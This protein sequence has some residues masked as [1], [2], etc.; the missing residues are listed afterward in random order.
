MSWLIGC[1]AEAVFLCG[2]P[3]GCPSL[4]PRLKSIRIGSSCV[5]VM[6]FAHI[7]RSPSSSP[8]MTVTLSTTQAYGKFRWAKLVC[9]NKLQN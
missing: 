4:G 1:P 9:L 8:S 3:F 7:Y 2:G 6:T 5:L